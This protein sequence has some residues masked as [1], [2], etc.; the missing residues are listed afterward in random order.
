MA[1]DQR[2]GRIFGHE[3]RLGDL[4]TLEPYQRDAAYHR[5]AVGRL[6]NGQTALVVIGGAG[7]TASR[8]AQAL[9][10][11]G[12][13]EALGM[14]IDSSANINWR[15]ASLNRPDHQRQIPT[16]I[17]V[18]RRGARSTSTPA[19]LPTVGRRWR[20]LAA[21]L[22]LIYVAAAGVILVTLHFLPTGLDPIR[23]LA[24]AAFASIAV[25]ASHLE[26]LAD[27]VAASIWART[28]RRLLSAGGRRDGGCGSL[29][30]GCASASS[31]QGSSD[32]PWRGGSPSCARTPP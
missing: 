14:D 16:G 13:V 21:V 24:G 3:R 22:G 32:W 4:T 9:L 11:L 15:G 31:G 12:F 20:M 10:R 7:T 17:I 23:L 18:F 19:F 30:P 5:T 2:H 28:R 26:C 1:D 25:A 29:R 27:R 6:R 8:F